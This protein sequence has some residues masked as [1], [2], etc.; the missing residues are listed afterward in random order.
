[1][2]RVFLFLISFL[3]LF[4]LTSTKISAQGTF[5]CTWTGV[6]CVVDHVGCEAGY[7]YSDAVCNAIT[8]APDCNASINNTCLS[9]LPVQPVYCYECGAG[10]NGAACNPVSPTDPNCLYRGATQD[11]AHNACLA[12]CKGSIPPTYMYSCI[13]NKCV[14]D[15]NGTN[16]STDC[17][18]VNNPG[19]DVRC[20]GDNTGINTAIGCIHVLGTPETFLADILKWAVGIGGG[21]AFLLILYAG[22][23]IMTAAGNPD[24][25]KA[26]QELL[27]SAISGLILL[28][29]SI[30]ILKFIGIDILG[31]CNFGF[32]TCPP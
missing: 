29:F 20:P 4:L 3:I 12:N 30:F 8:N 9:N 11:E 1:M 19:M 17:C 10:S 7:T 27:T 21:L 26:G 31:L 5:S 28:I 18:K 22:F 25:L 23:M 6:K 16:P 13:N 32:G 24:R 2:K 15:P 14:I